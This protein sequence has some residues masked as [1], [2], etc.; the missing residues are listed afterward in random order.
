[1]TTGAAAHFA[2]GFW[3]LMNGIGYGTSLASVSENATTK[4]NAIAGADQ[5]QRRHTEELYD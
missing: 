1:M 4:G 5:Q 2:G 3:A